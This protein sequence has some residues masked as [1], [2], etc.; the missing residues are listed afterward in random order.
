MY[1]VHLSI[2]F[3]SFSG[4]GASDAPLESGGRSGHAG[5]VLQER[6]DGPR[7]GTKHAAAVA[8]REREGRQGRGER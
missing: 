3:L 1:G 7:P 2:Y 8:A 4:T 6:E 5:A